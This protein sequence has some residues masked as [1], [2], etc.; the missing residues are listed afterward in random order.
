MGLT[1][2]P[3]KY[4]GAAFTAGAIGGAALAGL[5]SPGDFDPRADAHLGT[6]TGAP[7]HLSAYSH[8][9]CPPAGP[10]DPTGRSNPITIVF[11]GTGKD[12]V[13]DHLKHHGMSRTDWRFS[14]DPPLLPEIGFDN[15]FESAQKFYGHGHCQEEDGQAADKQF[16]RIFA[17]PPEEGLD[18]RHHMRFWQGRDTFD[19]DGY[20]YDLLLGPYTVGTPHHELFTITTTGCTLRPWTHAPYDDEEVIDGWAGGFIQAR[21]WIL[22]Q[23]VESGGGHQLAA[24]AQLWRNTDVFGTGHFD[25][26][27]LR[28]W[29]ASNA[30]GVVYY[31][32]DHHTQSSGFGG[33]GGTKIGL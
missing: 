8:G 5:T 32:E 24:Q 13:F 14:V 9:E 12:A 30:D 1:L 15:P 10:L 4:L 21:E 23:W 11:T 33:L 17:E 28:C 20:D 29:E 2:P 25:I 7:S 27:R 6:D 31:I 22:D 18:D 16:Y 3:R 26:T 19:P